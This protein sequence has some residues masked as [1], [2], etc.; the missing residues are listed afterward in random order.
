M[1]RSIPRSLS[2]N[3]SAN[4]LGKG[5]S[6]LLGVFFVPLYTRIIGIE[7]L[8]IL[9]L[10]ASVQGIL[11]ILDMG[12]SATV[13]RELALGSSGIRNVGESRD[14]VRTLEW[15]YWGLAAGIAVLFGSLAPLVADWVK[16]EAL[17]P[18]TITSAGMLLAVQLAVQFPQSLYSGGLQ[19]L[20]KQVLLNGITSITNVARHVG[21]LIPLLLVKPDIIVFV[22]WQIGVITAGVLIT[23]WFLW[24][25]LPVDDHRPRFSG[26]VLKRIRHFSMGV[27]ATAIVTIP[28]T[29]LDKLIMSKILSLES[30][31]Y[32]M[33]AWQGAMGLTVLVA[34][35]FSALFPRFTS[36]LN[37]PEGGQPFGTIYAKSY[38]LLS[39]VLAPAA[40]SAI[41]F[42]KPLTSI[43]LHYN[44]AEAANI[45]APLLAILV[46]GT[47]CNG[48]MNLPY[49]VSLA[50]G[51]SHFALVQN[52]ISLVLYLP[53]IYL[54]TLRFG[55][56][57]SAACW[58]ALNLGY[59]LLSS[60]VL[61]KWF[62]PG[63]FSGWM[64]NAVVV[65]FLVAFAIAYGWY[66]LIPAH[67]P[68][69]VSLC[70]SI[71]AFVSGALALAWLLPGPKEMFKAALNRICLV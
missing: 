38:Q 3:I 5:V 32:Y 65:P 9:G 20:E 1:K 23:R 37:A 13:N 12:L 41:L 70:G 26:S 53:L 42:A 67:A 50:K 43:W 14:L 58:L 61:H 22:S 57:G 33:L 35:F 31:G 19:G 56:M 59:V 4:F 60:F 55:A 11:L 47:Y 2:L 64:R 15:I 62:L 8:G 51:K 28:L 18:D 49:A 25:S 10:F 69:S 27:G 6:G 7:S 44:G 36:V 68:A 21:V 71:L 16:A 29:T 30:Y 17:P 52:A 66:L 46:A 40:A 63:Q 54:M 45:V 24:R 39:L 34:P 48:L